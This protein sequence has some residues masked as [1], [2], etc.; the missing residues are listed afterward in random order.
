MSIKCEICG[1]NIM[2]QKGVYTCQSCGIEYS[3]DD[4]RDMIGSQQPISSQEAKVDINRTE[5]Q[6][7]TEAMVQ[8]S[9][10]E[11]TRRI[12]KYDCL[13]IPF[14]E[15]ED[16]NKGIDLDGFP[17]SNRTIIGLLRERADAINS[18]HEGYSEYGWT[19][20]DVIN[21]GRYPQDAYL[22]YRP[23]PIEWIVYG[24]YTGKALLVSKE[25]L[26]SEKQ[27]SEKSTGNS[28]YDSDIRRLLNHDFYQTAFNDDEREI[29]CLTFNN[30]WEVCRFGSS[31]NIEFVVP[32]YPTYIRD[33]VF[34]LSATEATKGDPGVRI[35]PM[36][37]NAS[38]TDDARANLIGNT[39][40]WLR[41][42]AYGNDKNIGVCVYQ[43][44]FRF[45][46]DDVNERASN[47]I[48]KDKRKYC[49]IRPA[50][51][52]DIYDF[53]QKADLLSEYNKA[54][55]EEE[56]TEDS[57]SEIYPYENINDIARSDGFDIDDDGH[58][59]PRPDW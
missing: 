39:E 21:F 40:W 54:I 52:I 19:V 11:D 23:T 59:I 42:K 18:Q 29:I 16:I 58:W 9:Q 7:K 2:R 35:S 41:T 46:P 6:E 38:V 50:L 8:S 53:E 25:I 10:Q 27:I 43:N 5:S 1:G 14:D 30:V 45:N 31:N 57:E 55:E 12:P 49:G 13:F 37:D 20:G 22:N 51:W 3:V 4:L 17:E 33:S 36:L 48:T 28:L 47:I 34:V 44:A 24:L 56:V 26:L 15:T 32:S